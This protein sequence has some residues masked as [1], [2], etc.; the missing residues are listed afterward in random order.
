MIDEDAKA[1]FEAARAS[2]LQ[3]E[4]ARNMAEALAMSRGNRAAKQHD[5]KYDQPP[6]WLVRHCRL[7]LISKINLPSDLKDVI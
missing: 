7:G 4:R 6:P 3:V 5:N 2:L 1:R